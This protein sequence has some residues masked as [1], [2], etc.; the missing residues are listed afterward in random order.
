MQCGSS[1]VQPYVH[2]ASLL[3]FKNEHLV[4]HVDGT[5]S[6]THAMDMFHI[7]KHPALH[8]TE[9]RIAHSGKPVKFHLPQNL[10]V[11]AV[12]HP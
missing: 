1:G 10:A 7:N 3:L 12:I 2:Q 4:I 8:L 11:F 6:A 9:T 5:Q